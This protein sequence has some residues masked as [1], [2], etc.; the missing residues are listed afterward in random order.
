[1]ARIVVKVQPGAKAEGLVG[2]E[3]DALKV[4]V[5]APA[6]E[7]RANQAVE[8]L[9][10]ARIGVARGTVKVVRGAASRLKWVE[11]EGLDR[12]ALEARIS[13]ALEADLGESK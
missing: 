10:A 3:G 2:R 12:E 7:G 9:L 5:R 11:V 13:A 4:K 1:V 6:R 8:A